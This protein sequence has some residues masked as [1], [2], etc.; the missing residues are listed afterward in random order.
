MSGTNEAALAQYYRILEN[1]T[2]VFV[3]GC[4]DEEWNAMSRVAFCQEE[5]R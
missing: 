5:V 3:A 2:E 4:E 1:D